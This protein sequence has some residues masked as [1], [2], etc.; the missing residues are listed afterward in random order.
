MLKRTAL[1]A[2]VYGAFGG[3]ALLTLAACDGNPAA[4]PARIEA[5][6]AEA[7]APARAERVQPASYEPP[8]SETG[9]TRRAAADREPAAAVPLFKGKPMWSENRNHTAEEN[10]QYQYD[11]HGQELGAKSLDDFLSKTHAFVDRPAKDVLVKTRANGDRL[12]YD[13]QTGLFAVARSDGAPRTVFKP[14]DG[15]AY[16]KAQ[17]TGSSSQ[18]RRSGSSA[19]EG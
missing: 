1:C 5:A 18:A 7:P 19:D 6:T 14:N 3:L 9:A 11:Q 2:V 4:T 8:R 13:P 12:M 10:A 15:E 16:W 17:S